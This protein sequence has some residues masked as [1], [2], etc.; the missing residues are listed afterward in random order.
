MKGEV[1]VRFVC[2]GCGTT[3][4]VSKHSEPAEVLSNLEETV[5]LGDLTCPH[6]GDVIPTEMPV[7]KR[8]LLRRIEDLERRVALTEL[9]LSPPTVTTSY[10]P[11]IEYHGNVPPGTSV[12]FGG[13]GAEP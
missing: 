4:L 2:E 3:L 7:G 1:E 11:P 6:C 9:R 10:P 12:T 5:T 13:T 8:E